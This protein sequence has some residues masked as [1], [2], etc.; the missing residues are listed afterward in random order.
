VTDSVGKHGSEPESAWAQ[1]AQLSFR[2][3]F[4]VVFLFGIGWALS[5]CREVPA[6]SRAVVLRLG[7]VVRERGA[8]LLLAL[9]QPLERVIILPAP[10]RQIEFKVAA[11]ESGGMISEDPRKN[12]ALLLT[13]DMSVVNLNASVFYQITDA[14]AYILSS[15][16]VEP[17]LARLYASS[18]V[19]VT[20]GRDLDTILVAR[21]ERNATNDAA[22]AGRESLRADLVAEVNRRLADLVTR[23]VSLGIRV[24]RVDLV[25][26]I[27]ADAK[28]AFDAVLFS[29]QQAQTTIAEARTQ[30]E[31][32]RQRANE[33][34]DRILRDAQARRQ[35]Q[36]NEA[37]TRTAAIV[38]LSHDA[39]GLSGD[40][41]S[42]QLYR[43][44]IV[45]IL[46]QAGK[47][48]SADGTGAARLILPAGGHH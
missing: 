8:G 10:N 16:H 9:P 14:D 25:P 13:G 17:A 3:L 30:A 37:E 33:D 44:Q 22:R 15:A 34:A 36:V 45:G 23:G 27:P 20:A 40:M 29:L 19:A 43:E 47:V 5:N 35:E 42:Q 6:D 18:A 26:A 28:G 48:F 32:T 46:G 21:P 41:L 39:H 24:S 2:F 4:I 11:S 7:T 12:A 1:S 38:A 31:M